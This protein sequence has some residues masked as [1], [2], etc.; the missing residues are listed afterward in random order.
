[1][2]MCEEKILTRQGLFWGLHQLH[3]RGARHWHYRMCLKRLIHIP[4]PIL[5]GFGLQVPVN[6]LLQSI[7]PSRRL[8]PSKGTKLIAPNVVSP[9]KG[10]SVLSLS[11]GKSIQNWRKSTVLVGTLKPHWKHLN[12]LHH[13]LTYSHRLQEQSMDHSDMQPGMIMILPIRAHW[14]WQSGI[15]DHGN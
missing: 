8:F 10:N 7:L 1:M 6:C 13:I 9:D 11:E 3:M 14:S 15:T 4:E 12:A 5:I 2:S